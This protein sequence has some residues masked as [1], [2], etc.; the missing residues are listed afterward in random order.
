M[1]HGT[2]LL[3]LALAHPLYPAVLIVC[4]SCAIR[5]VDGTYS[6]STWYTETAWDMSQIYSLFVGD[7]KTTV[8]SEVSPL[9]FMTILF[10]FVF[11]F[12]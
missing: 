8:R 4:L 12:S 3:Y 11:G 5:R 10:F 7:R 2:N 9:N 1:A 6:L